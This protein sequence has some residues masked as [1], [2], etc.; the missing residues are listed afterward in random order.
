MHVRLQ[1]WLPMTIQVCINGR[2][3][4]A[5]RMDKAGM[6][7][8]KRGIPQR[9]LSITRQSCNAAFQLSRCNAIHGPPA[10]SRVGFVYFAHTS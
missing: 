10:G 9:Y 6:R 3:Y 8:E 1:T 2:E 4:L 5:R 7:Y